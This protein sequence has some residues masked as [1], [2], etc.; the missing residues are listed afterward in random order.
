MSVASVE[1]F[2]DLDLRT[3]VAEILGRWPSAGALGP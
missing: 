2:A 3:R 1:A